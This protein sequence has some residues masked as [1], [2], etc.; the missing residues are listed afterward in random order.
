MI[1][2]ILSTEQELLEFASRWA[3]Q[4]KPGMII[5]LEGP[6]GVGKTTFVRGLLRGLGYQS[7]VKSPTYTLVES[8]EIADKKIFHFDLYRLMNVSELE[9]MGIR[10]YFTHDSICIIEWAE[11]GEPLLPSADIICYFSF[12]DHGREMQCE[13]N[14]ESGQELL[15]RII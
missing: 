4:L 1:K 6:L 2:K 12:H 8:Y 7:K 3:V 9:E 5:F 13:T 15:K 10:D 11:K 14:S